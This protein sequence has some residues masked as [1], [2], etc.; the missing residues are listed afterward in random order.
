MIILEVQN[1]D[2]VFIRKDNRNLV[3]GKKVYLAP[4]DSINNYEEIDT[5]IEEDI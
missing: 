5:P 1:Q 3:V 2:N 4:S